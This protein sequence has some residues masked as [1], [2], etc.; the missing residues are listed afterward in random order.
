MASELD[1]NRWIARPDNAFDHLG[2]SRYDDPPTEMLRQRY[3][4]HTVETLSCCACSSPC[5]FFL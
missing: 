4:R 1:A 3:Q 2:E 5:E